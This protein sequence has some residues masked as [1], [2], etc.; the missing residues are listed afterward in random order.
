MGH[1]VA[2]GEIREVWSGNREIQATLADPVRFDTRFQ[3]GLSGNPAGRPLGARNRATV[4]RE[5]ALAG[6]AVRVMEDLLARAEAGDLAAARLVL[7]RLIPAGLGGGVDLAPATSAADIVEALGRLAA[8]TAAGDLAPAQANAVTRML[9]LQLQALP[10]RAKEE[11][12][13]AAAEA[14]IETVRA[15]KAG[16]ARPAEAAAAPVPSAAPSPSACARAARP[17]CH[18]RLVPMAEWLKLNGL[19]QSLPAALAKVR[20][21][22]G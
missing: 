5:A 13:T 2:E 7:A 21:A 19:E 14:M 8:A 9:Q 6:R 20:G 3:P 1:A 12:E 15:M 18:G 16:R 11:E 17:A 22:S 4:L 10:A